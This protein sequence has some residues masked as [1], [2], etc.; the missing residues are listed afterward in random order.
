[1]SIDE[2]ILI[3]SQDYEIFFQDSGSV[4]KCL[5]E[6]TD[7]LRNFALRRG[8][9][10]TFF[11]D[12]GMLVAMRRVAAKDKHVA[13]ELSKIC[14]QLQLL[15]KDK[16]ELGLHVHPHWEDTSWKD[17]KWSFGGTRF[18][19][20]EFSSAEIAY[21]FHQYSD[22][23]AELSGKRP[24]S[25]R[26]GG[27]CAE[28]F[29]DIGAALTAIG[30]TIDSSVV[31]GAVL[32]DGEKGFDFGAAPD[33][34]YWQFKTDPSS[35]SDDGPFVEVPITPQRLPRMYYWRRLI[36]RL[37]VVRE[38]NQFGDGVSKA[39][40]ML[41]VIRRLASMSRIAELS[42]DDAKAE[43]LKANSIVNQNRDVWHL[44]GHPK[45]LSTNSLQ[46]LQEFIEQHHL[47]RTETVSEFAETVSS[48]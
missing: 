1:M 2:P 22:C 38:S 12:V 23:L 27:F 21:I 29:S 28:P 6:P 4:E 25:Y 24:T 35:P 48:D 20:K 17:G 43:Q 42:I 40:G 3:L 30:I 45:L 33:L 26:A 18:S 36:E 19:L 32:R 37:G 5:F 41:E 31:P 13:S 39:I 9:R 44:M 11:V 34:P 15:A 47:I 14:R 10:I 7:A 16:H 8:L 46:F